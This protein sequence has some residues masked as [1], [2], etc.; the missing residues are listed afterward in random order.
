MLVLNQILWRAV[1]RNLLLTAK[2][3]ENTESKKNLKILSLFSP[4]SQ[5][6]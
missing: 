3:T 4:F 1:F 6:P 2:D 5:G